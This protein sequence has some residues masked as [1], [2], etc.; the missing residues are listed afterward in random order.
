[1]ST[2][3]RDEDREAQDEVEREGADAL[4][5]EAVVQDAEHAGAEE[6]ADDGAAAAGQ[7]V[8]PMTAAEIAAN[9]IPGRPPAGRSR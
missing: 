4:E 8:P 5:R 7:R 3:H 1:M 2:H 9:M 6:R